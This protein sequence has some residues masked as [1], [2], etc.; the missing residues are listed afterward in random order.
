ML[1]PFGTEE[2]TKSQLPVARCPLPAARNSV[3]ETR[4][5]AGPGLAVI[6]LRVIRFKTRFEN[7][8]TQ[9][10]ITAN[11]R[12]AT[13]RVFRFSSAQPFACLAL[14]NPGSTMRCPS[15]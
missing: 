12:P 13:E 9:D 7:P 1:A 14:S 11:P 8:T 6:Q 4:S 2:Y 3:E 15:F 10:W 5:V